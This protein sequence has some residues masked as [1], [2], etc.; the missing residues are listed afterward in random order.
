MASKP[1]TKTKRNEYLKIKDEWYKKLKASGFND[2]EHKDG[3]INPSH[4]RRQQKHPIY[5]EAIQEYYYMCYHFLHEYAF[6]NEIER[7]I[8]EYHTE[9]VGVRD[10]ADTLHKVK[11]SKI[12]K[13]MVFYILKKLEQEMKSRY[14]QV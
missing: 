5:R 6:P 13:S 12:K 8:W 14:L 10:I 3:S 2:I 1:Q 11:L 7:V 4:I 9:G